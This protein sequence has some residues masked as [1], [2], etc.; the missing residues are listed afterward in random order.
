[1]KHIYTS[2]LILFLINNSFSQ[3]IKGV[4]INEKNNEPIPYVS[5]GI[6]GEYYGTYS[7]NLGEFELTLKEFSRNDS[8]RF[9]CIGF[10]SV[11]FNVF[12]L[13]NRIPENIPFVVKLTPK[14]YKIQEVAVFSNKKKTI[15][16]G[17]KRS[18]ERILLGI[19][20]DKE[21][22]VVFKNKRNLLLKEVSFKLSTSW[23]NAPD[24]AI[25]RF[26]IYTLENG[27]P[28]E[29]ILTQPIYFYLINESFN[30]YS[31]FDISEYN[32]KI[33]QDFAATFELVKQYGGHRVYFTGQL[34]GN[35][36]IHRKGQQGIW[37]DSYENTP[38]NLK[39]SLIINALIE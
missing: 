32:I 28:K 16:I 15:K 39:Q 7:S 34:T 9:S 21:L 2:F 38:L 20:D 6:I 36:S 29:N 1:M 25:F 24:S 4:V 17:N 27:L 14:D 10:E 31:T 37:F 3:S 35:K 12:E 13:T 19:F 18:G 26:N 8:L 33:N 11:S 30:G 22:G 5:V 23:G